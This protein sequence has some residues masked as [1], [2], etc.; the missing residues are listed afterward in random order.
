VNLVTTLLMTAHRRRRIRSHPVDAYPPST[1]GKR[2]TSCIK[3]KPWGAPYR[4][5][6]DFHRGESRGSIQTSRKSWASE[7]EFSHAH[8]AIW[9]ATPL[10][11]ATKVT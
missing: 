9:A 2:L 5:F 11:A 8:L 3:L 6:E 10:Q 1:E 4:D 7:R